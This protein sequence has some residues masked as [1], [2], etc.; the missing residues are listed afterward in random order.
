METELTIQ[1]VATLTGLSVH[2]LRYYERNG[3]L[4]PVNRAANG[5]RRYSAMD[6]ARIKFLT[7]LRTTGMPIRQMQKFADLYRQKPE[8]IA[9]R[10][11]I[12]EAHEREV[13]Q[14]ICEL[15]HN[16]EMI[17]KKIQHYKELEANH[18]LDDACIGDL[19]EAQLSLEMATTPN[20][21]ELRQV[22]TDNHIHVHYTNR[23][24]GEKIYEN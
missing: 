10:R 12:L 20:S 6:I 21:L 11:L 22:P 4:A 16:L 7:R 13:T 24:F 2:T 18:Q 23:N 5:H 19:S 17:Q 14:R 15:N 3:L 9:E 8:A 1:Q